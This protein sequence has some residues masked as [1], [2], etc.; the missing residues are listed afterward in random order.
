VRLGARDAR[1]SDCRR[2]HA[3]NVQRR[4]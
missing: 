2:G 1:R 3:V 4:R